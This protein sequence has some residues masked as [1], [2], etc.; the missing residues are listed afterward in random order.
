MLNINSTA[1]AEQASECVANTE[2]YTQEG[3]KKRMAVFAQNGK[4]VKNIFPS[5]LGHFSF[6]DEIELKDHTRVTYWTGGC[7][8][9]GFSFTFEGTAIKAVKGNKKLFRG[10]TLLKALDLI[11]NEERQILLKALA[12]AKKQKRLSG[13]SPGVYSLPCG[14]ATCALTDRGDQ[15]VTIAYDFAL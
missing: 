7:A 6:I 13:T 1:L 4:N 15:K 10:E 5:K 9:I 11:K 3:L 14:D 2:S 8:H 12:E